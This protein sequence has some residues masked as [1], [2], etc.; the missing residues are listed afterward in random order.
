M[1]ISNIYFLVVALLITVASCNEREPEVSPL[2]ENFPFRMELDLDE[3]GALP[4]EEDYGLEIKFADYLGD[5]P[6]NPI[7]L[8]YEIT[9]VVDDFTGVVEIIEVLYKVEIDDCEY[10]REI[11]FTGSQIVIPVDTDLGTVPEEFE[12]VFAL[13]GLDN[14]SGGFVFT[15]TGISSEA[16]VLFNLAPSFEYAVL[17][18]EAAGEWVLEIA[19]EQQF[20]E[21]KEIFGPVSQGLD[22]LNFSDITGE[23]VFELEYT[24]MKIEIELV[25]PDIEEVCEEDMTES[26]EVHLEI[27]DME[28]EVEDGE[29]AIEG[30]Y[31]VED[32]GVVEE[33]DFEVEAVYTIVAEQLIITF[34]SVIDEDNYAE[35][36]ELFFREGGL[37][38]TLNR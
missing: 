13:P 8:T 3:G 27:G 28:W 33:F 24:E 1:K 20:Q 9:D 38:F 5:L 7:T 12:V 10:E 2:D 21:F 26:E 34:I 25:N 16:D 30:S 37:S 11:S 23:V 31:A 32:E 35:G 19:D 36:E 18:E 29:L 17:D 14:T 4:D 6:S 15:V 22:A